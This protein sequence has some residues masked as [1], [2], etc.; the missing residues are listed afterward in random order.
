MTD[1]RKT[2]NYSNKIFVE[3][4]PK[5]VSVIPE[6]Q[7]TFDQYLNLHQTLMG[8]ANLTADE[9]KETFRSLKPNKS[10]AYDN[11]SSDVLNETSDI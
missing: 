7:T 9:L 4:G 11:I 6:L 5:L 1:Y 10:S 3:I 2:A 8:E